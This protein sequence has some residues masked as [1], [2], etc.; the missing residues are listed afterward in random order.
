M[1]P[2]AALRTGSVLRAAASLS[3]IGGTVLLAFDDKVTAGLTLGVSV[4]VM[5]KILV[6]YGALFGAAVWTARYAKD[7]SPV[8]A[9]VDRS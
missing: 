6:T 2:G 1:S 4:W 5:A 9:R 7:R 8:R 3:L